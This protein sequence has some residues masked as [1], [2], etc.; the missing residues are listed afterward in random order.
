MDG[1]SGE[2]S[3]GNGLET[4][5]EWAVRVIVKVLSQ[6]NLPHCCPQEDTVNSSDFWNILESLFHSLIIQRPRK[7][8]RS[9]GPASYHDVW[10]RGKGITLI[11][12]G[13]LHLPILHAGGI[14]ARWKGEAEQNTNKLDKCPPRPPTFGENKKVFK[15]WKLQLYIN[16]LGNAFT[17]FPVIE[18]CKSF[19]QAHNF[20]PTS[21]C[22]PWPWFLLCTLSCSLALDC[23][24]CWF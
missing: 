24:F 19:R 12:C 3:S 10:G 15:F 18:P 8:G 17:L 21:L 22:K 2:Q 5:R 16:Y 13:T 4:K 7:E 14:P 23:F 6:D 20:T 1:K 11:P 9:L